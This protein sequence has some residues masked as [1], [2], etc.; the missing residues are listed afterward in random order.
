M[1]SRAK[2]KVT[3]SNVEF[4][5]ADI[6]Q[7]LNFADGSFDLVSCN[8]VLEHIKNLQPVFSEISRVLKFGGK[9]FVSELHPMKQY[10]GSKARFTQTTPDG[11]SGD[12]FVLD[13]FI[14]HTSDFFNCAMSNG[15][16]CILLDE[17]FDES[18]ELAVPRL[19]TFLFEKQ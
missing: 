18:S 5:T 12:T 3:A 4:I 16:Q 19:I 15:F 9:F 1:I 14:H 7:R 13:C 6:S 17:W 8:L 2:E 10:E 11:M